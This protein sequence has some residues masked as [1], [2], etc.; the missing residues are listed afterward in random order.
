MDSFSCHEISNIT[1]LVYDD[2][3]LHAG[4]GMC[5]FAYPPVLPE[6]RLNRPAL[7]GI[8]TRSDNPS[9]PQFK[10]TPRTGFHIGAGIM[11]VGE[12]FL[13]QLHV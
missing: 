2:S 8:L 11:A 5:Y 7:L 1:Y 4:M 6:K 13:E 3:F 12:F 9:L 10:I